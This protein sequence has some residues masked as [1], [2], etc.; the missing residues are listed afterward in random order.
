MNTI[1]LSICT[2]LLLCTILSCFFLCGGLHN[3]FQKFGSF[4]QNITNKM[5]HEEHN[6]LRPLL[7]NDPCT[8]TKINNN[9]DCWYG[10]WDG[11]ATCEKN[12]LFD[13]AWAV[14]M[15][16]SIVLLACLTSTL[17]LKRITGL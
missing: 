13:K 1:V 12:Q 4:G 9:T 8:Y 10:T 15:M 11:M 3:P 5:C 2:V 17:V 6:R 16:V 7:K 14:L